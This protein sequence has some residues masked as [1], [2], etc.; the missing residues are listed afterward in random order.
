MNDEIELGYID[1]PIGYEKLN[2]EN[3][4]DICDLLIER[5]LIALDS[6]LPVY[7][8][9]ITFLKEVLESSLIT[10][11]REENYEVCS[12]IRDTIKR[13]DAV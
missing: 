12:V 4:D 10:N 7:I 6:E 11:E 13:I 9:R 5:L 3:K 1:V 2:P 8:S